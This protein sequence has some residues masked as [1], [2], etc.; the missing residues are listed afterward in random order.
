MK[1][2]V[3]EEFTRNIGVLTPEEQERLSS[4]KVAVAG[5]GGVGGLHLLTLAR[6]GIVNFAVGDPDTFE[7]VNINRQ[8][9]AS[10]STIGRNKAEVLAAMIRDINPTANVQVFREGVSQ[11]NIDRFLE[12]VDIFVDGVDFFEINIRRLIFNTCRAKG[13]YALT[14]APLGF[15]ATLQVFDPKG[16]SFDDYFG[17]DDETGYAEAIAAFA[18]G[19]SPMSLHVSY[20]DFSWVSMERRT[21]PAVSPACTLAASL[22]A[23]EAVK[24][25]TGK[26]EVLPIPHYLQFDMLLNRYVTGFLEL[27]GKDPQQLAKRAA[28]ME[29][30]A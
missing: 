6:L 12:G 21:G 3:Q 27:G 24:I 18:L 13:I 20:M 10:H 19:L 22:V 15:G 16:M 29:K 5:A 8:Y 28:I 30:F 25:V 1:Q 23:T 14:A 7:A 17:I 2:P 9:G 4:T 11:Q 26:G